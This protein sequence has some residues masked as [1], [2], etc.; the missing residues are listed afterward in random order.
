MSQKTLSIMLSEVPLEEVGDVLQPRKVDFHTSS[1]LEEWSASHAGI[2]RQLRIHETSHLLWDL[3]VEH[4]VNEAELDCNLN[5]CNLRPATQGPMWSGAAGIDI[6]KKVCTGF[7]AVG[8]WV[9]E[10]LQEPVMVQ[11]NN[12]LNIG[13]CVSNEVCIGGWEVSDHSFARKRELTHDDV[14]QSLNADALRPLG[15]FA[16]LRKADQAQRQSLSGRVLDLDSAK[17]SLA[18]VAVALVTLLCQLERIEVL[19][20]SHPDHTSCVSLADGLAGERE[21]GDIL[22]C[23]KGNH[24]KLE[25]LLTVSYWPVVVLCASKESGET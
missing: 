20:I 9:H 1:S 14:C 19:L 10:V 15:P 5:F 17:L 4:E 6:V 22:V 16:P 8:A 11:T 7:M 25:D 2:G 18:E 23:W 24:D 3:W 21:I 12:L 13:H